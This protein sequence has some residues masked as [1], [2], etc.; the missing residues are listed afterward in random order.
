MHILIFG[1]TK[2]EAV[3][4]ILPKYSVLKLLERC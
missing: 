4:Q 3:L 1:V 2:N